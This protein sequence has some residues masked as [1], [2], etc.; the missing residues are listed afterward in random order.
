MFSNFKYI[1]NLYD[2]FVFSLR[3]LSIYVAKIWGSPQP[4]KHK[5]EYLL[6]ITLSK[7]KNHTKARNLYRNHTQ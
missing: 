6:Q 7:A 1:Q 4:S 5:E 2:S 3:N